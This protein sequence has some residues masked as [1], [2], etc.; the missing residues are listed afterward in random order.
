[1]FTHFGINTLKNNKNVPHNI[2]LL[3]KTPKK[4]SLQNTNE[5]NKMEIRS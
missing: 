2:V 5:N 1:M 4:I 3:R